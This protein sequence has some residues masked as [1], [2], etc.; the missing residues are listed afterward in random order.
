MSRSGYS[1]DC[2]NDWELIMWRGAVSS[3]LRGKRGQEFLK[4]MLVSLDALPQK[5]LIA[6]E[7]KTA[8]GEVCALGCVGISRKIDMTSIDIEEPGQV[9]NVFGI[10][11][12]MAAEIQFINDDDFAY[13]QETPE[14]RY[15]RVREWAVLQIKNKSDEVNR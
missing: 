11:L 12:A 7:L 4:E 14:A 6:N 1:D 5:R 13:N 8:E 10:A 9:G 2:D 3:A 15:K